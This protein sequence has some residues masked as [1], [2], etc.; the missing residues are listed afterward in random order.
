MKK[1]IYILLLLAM[2][3]GSGFRVTFAADRPPA[4][5]PSNDQTNS[6]ESVAE[7]AQSKVPSS[8]IGSG[9]DSYQLVPKDQVLFRI[10]EDQNEAKFNAPQLLEVTSQKQ[11]H[12]PITRG[13]G[14]TI[15]INVTGKT[16]GTVREEIQKSLE[17]QYYKKATVRL[18]LYDQSKSYG[19][20]WFR[21]E[22]QGKYELKPG[23]ATTLSEALMELRPG[24]FANLKKVKVDRFDPVTQQNKSVV[25]NVKEIL[26]RGTRTQDWKLEDGDRIYVPPKGI[27]FF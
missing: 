12:F 1:N 20:V 2:G 23:A 3:L 9:S 8:E 6:A 16:L 5:A 25:I 14:E 26:D 13:M 4:N 17:A 7:P 22:V 18:A 15:S 27:N 11:V 24:D 21:G 19:V 10:G